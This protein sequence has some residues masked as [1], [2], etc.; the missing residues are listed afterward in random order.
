M[1]ARE[2]FV[3]RMFDASGQL[4]YVGC[5]N[6]P[7]RRWY[8]HRT[9]RPDMSAAAVKFKVQGPFTRFKAR[10]LEREAA[11]SEQPLFGWTPAKQSVITQ[12]NAF[13][14]RR[15]SVLQRSAGWD[16]ST[17]RRLAAVEADHKFGSEPSYYQPWRPECVS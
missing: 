9:E 14:R 3:Y 16:F 10:Q 4:L 15:T 7:K 5:T 12:R 17:A 13:M 1:N 6:N 11:T 8:E 2:F